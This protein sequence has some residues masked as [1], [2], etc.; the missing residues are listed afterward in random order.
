MFEGGVML[1]GL[2]EEYFECA[3]FIIE[4]GASVHI[5]GFSGLDPFYWA[6]ACRNLKLVESM[7][8]CGAAD[9]NHSYGDQYPAIIFMVAQR[10]HE[11]T[12]RILLRYADDLTLKN[13]SGQTALDVAQIN[14]RLG[15]IAL[16]E[17][18]N[19]SSCVLNEQY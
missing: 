7:L 6:N 18:T 12:V 19:S 4:N 8:A 16:L 10:G 2:D 13:N 11:E 5:G 15:V 14:H 1:G 9:I 3:K 17:K